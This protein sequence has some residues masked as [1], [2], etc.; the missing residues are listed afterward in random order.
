MFGEHRD[1][2]KIEMQ[3]WTGIAMQE[4][5]IPPHTVQIWKRNDIERWYKKVIKKC[6]YDE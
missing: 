1:Y 4:C 5:G 2:D 3:I 6:Y